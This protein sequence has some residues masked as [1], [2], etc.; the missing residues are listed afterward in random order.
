MMSNSGRL[1]VAVIGAGA[2]GLCAARHLLARQD[3]F[4]PPVLYELTKRVGGT[5]VYEERVGRD[6]DD[7]P[8]YSSMYRDLR[9]NIPKEVMAFP[10]FPFDKHLPSFVHH[11]EVRKYLNQYCDHFGIRE[12]IKFHRLVESVRPVFSESRQG[13]LTWDVTTSDA[14]GKGHKTTNQ[15][16]AVMVCNGH[17]FDP[18]IPPIAGLENFKGMLMHSHDY[19]VAEPFAGKSVV[20]LGAGLSGMDIMIELSEVAS[21]VTLSHRQ[22]PLTCPLPRG[23]R[24]AQGVKLI[25]EDGELVFEDGDRA[26]PDVFM[27][28]TGYNFTFPFLSKEEVGLQVREHCVTPLY[29]HLL[30]PAFPSLFLIGICRAICPFPHFHCQIQFALSVL[31]GSFTLPTQ[32]QM[33]EEMEVD[34]Q[35]QLQKGT[36][37]RHI[38]KLDSEQWDYN[39]EMAR[40]GKFKPLPPFW[41]NLYEANKV[42]RAQDLLNYKN[43]IYQVFSDHEWTVMQKGAE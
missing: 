34:M 27:L 24:Q 29:K 6:E 4:C 31:D 39:D 3:V 28:C 32:K 23:V 40:L 38:L 25:N 7:L 17:F 36:A 42:F 13:G 33:E 20:L 19:R 15:F 2:A 41:K 18:Y 8:V 22:R 5:W 1:Q 12:H 11:T 16:D 30:H 37:L 35:T 43:Y 9:T 10:D 21:E 26:K 14:T